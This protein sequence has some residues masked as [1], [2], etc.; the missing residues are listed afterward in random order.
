MRKSKKLLTAAAAKLPDISLPSLGRT[1]KPSRV[2]KPL[3][4]LGA[5]IGTGVV[6]VATQALFSN[7]YQVGEAQMV[8]LVEREDGSVVVM[9]YRHTFC[10]PAAVAAVVTT[11][12]EG[13]LMPFRIDTWRS[14]DGM[15]C[16]TVGATLSV[17]RRS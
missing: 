10:A 11:F 15:H 5:L 17:P 13:E 8:K 4:I 7:R 2:R 3:T 12:K 9:L 16:G 14:V 1:E 6:G